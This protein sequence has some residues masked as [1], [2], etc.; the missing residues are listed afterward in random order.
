MIINGIDLYEVMNR[1]NQ[2]TNQ[3]KKSKGIKTNL[4]QVKEYLSRLMIHI[5]S[6]LYAHIIHRWALRGIDQANQYPIGSI[7]EANA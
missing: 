3:K 5:K 7:I 4:N 6:T 2:P 1:T